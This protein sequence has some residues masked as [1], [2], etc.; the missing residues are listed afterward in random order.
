M[1]VFFVG[2]MAGAMM[3]V[4]VIA[5]LSANGRGGGGDE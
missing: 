2:M 1:I 3:A 4:T 5:L